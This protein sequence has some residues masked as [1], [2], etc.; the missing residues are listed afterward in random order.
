MIKLVRGTAN[1]L[2][3]KVIAFS[4]CNNAEE[5]ITELKAIYASVKPEDYFEKFGSNSEEQD[6]MRKKKDEFCKRIDEISKKLGVD[7]RLNLTLAHIGE[8]PVSVEADIFLGNEDI[9]DAGTFS[10]KESCYAAMKAAID[11]YLTKFNDGP[12]KNKEK[13]ETM[14]KE[15]KE[16]T[17]RDIARES[18]NNYLA[19]K[20]IGPIIDA[21]MERNIQR[22]S[23]LEKEFLKFSAGAPFATDVIDIMRII[24]EKQEKIDLG[25][26]T[27]YFLKISAINLEKYEIAAEIRDR[28]KKRA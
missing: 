8:I 10:K 4:R 15:E 18:L 3:G 26:I 22:V 7:M 23:E 9:I 17:Y 21:C 1:N 16:T 27:D 14:I 25:L 11:L 24:R 19:G 20:F 12:S 28:I 2:E 13:N 5:G 6:E